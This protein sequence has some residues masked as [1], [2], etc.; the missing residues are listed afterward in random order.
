MQQ[1]LGFGKALEHSAAVRRQPHLIVPAKGL[2]AGVR[3]G[4]PCSAN[5]GDKGFAV[6]EA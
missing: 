4:T 3:R 5:R 2:I 6:L 1:L